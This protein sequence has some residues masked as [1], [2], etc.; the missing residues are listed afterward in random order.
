[1]LIIT[2]PVLGS[3]MEK[4][5]IFI[6]SKV[7]IS[8]YD[9]IYPVTT[10]SVYAV[11]SGRDTTTATKYWA[12]HAGNG[13]YTWSDINPYFYDI[14]AKRPLLGSVTKEATGIHLGHRIPVFVAD[15]NT[16]SVS[17]GDMW[18]NSTSHRLKFCVSLDPDTF[19]VFCWENY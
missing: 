15:P 19:K 14:Y 9:L 6:W 13:V 18:Y 11:I 17:V 5:H 2:L 8:G 12:S 4:N 16:D 10:A 7:T 1:M 3:I